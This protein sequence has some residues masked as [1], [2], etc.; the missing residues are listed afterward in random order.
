MPSW[1][2]GCILWAYDDEF[3]LSY[4]R[5]IATHSTKQNRLCW[6]GFVVGGRG[7]IRCASWFFDRSE[8]LQKSALLPTS[9]SRNPIASFG[10]LRRTGWFCLYFP[11]PLNKKPTLLGW[12]VW[13]GKVDSNHRSQWQQI[14]SLPPLATREFPHIW[15]FFPLGEPCLLSAYI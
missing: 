9:Q 5:N 6:V 14:Y 10:L 1:N 11:L 4:F 13:W 7:R 15:C 2:G 12:L 3:F 8:R